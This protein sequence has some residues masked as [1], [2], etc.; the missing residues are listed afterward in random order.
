MVVGEAVDIVYYR[1]LGA[2]GSERE[3]IRLPSL[4][5]CGKLPH[6]LSK[7]PLFCRALS[8]LRVLH[9]GGQRELTMLHGAHDA[10]TSPM[11]GRDLD[12]E[13]AAR[14]LVLLPELRWPV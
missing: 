7:G 5:P 8:A 12:R 14:L 9:D 11:V 13:L 3:H 10:K 6:G 2:A 4:H 1:V